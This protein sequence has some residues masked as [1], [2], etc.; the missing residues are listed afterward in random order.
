MSK[1][2]A[3]LDFDITPTRL[4][5]GTETVGLYDVAEIG[6]L[7]SRENVR[8]KCSAIMSVPLF[9]FIDSEGDGLAICKL[10]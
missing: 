6:L 1:A 4:P 8:D 5:G 2:L 3:R 10:A 7:L 9:G